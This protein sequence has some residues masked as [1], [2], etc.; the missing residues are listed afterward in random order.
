[1]RGTQTSYLLPLA[2]G[3]EPVKEYPGFTCFELRQQPAPAGMLDYATGHYDS[4][5][6]RIES[7]WR[8]NDADGSVTYQ[9]TIPAN[10]QA[11]VTLPCMKPFTLG[12]GRYRYSVS[13]A[14]K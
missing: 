6:G 10:T 13:G 11:Q 8:R 9:F 12:S 4:P 14:G 3:I 5:Y 1:M 7:S 2:L